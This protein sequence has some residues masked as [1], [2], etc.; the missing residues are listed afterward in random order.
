[1]WKEEKS[2]IRVVQMD[3]LRGLLGIKTMAKV[4][5]AKKAGIVNEK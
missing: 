5:N 2:T 3:N 1:M 4:L